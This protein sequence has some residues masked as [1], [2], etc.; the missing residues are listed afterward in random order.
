LPQSAA[1]PYLGFS[2]Q[3]GRMLELLL[4]GNMNDVISLEHFD[5][6]GVESPTG[7]PKKVVQAKNSEEGNPV[8]LI[9]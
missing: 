4:D 6:L 7:E 5:D 1:G 9:R 2:L 3:G 8:G